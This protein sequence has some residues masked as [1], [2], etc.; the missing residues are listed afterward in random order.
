VRYFLTANPEATV[1]IAAPPIAAIRI[2]IQGVPLLLSTGQPVFGTWRGLTCPAVPETG[3][4]VL[5][6]A[7]AAAVFV[8]AGEAGV[9]V[10]DFLA[11]C[12]PV[13][14]GVLVAV[15]VGLEVAVGVAAPGGG[16][17]TVVTGVPVAVLVAVTVAVRTTVTVTVGGALVELTTVVLVAVGVASDWHVLIATSFDGSESFMW[18]LA[19]GHDAAPLPAPTP[20]SSGDARWPPHSTY[21]VPAAFVIVTMDSRSPALQ[22]PCASTSVTE[23]M[24]ALIAENPSFDEPMVPPGVAGRLVLYGAMAR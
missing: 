8:A 1:A 21:A 16:G 14:I 2:S 6:A 22:L 9:G 15:S 5:A 3:V 13:G 7:S 11:G 20:A 17:A 10:C 24:V 4:G 19:P 18:R 23:S 12:V